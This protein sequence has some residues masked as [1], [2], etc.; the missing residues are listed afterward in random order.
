MRLNSCIEYD[1]FRFCSHDYYPFDARDIKKYVVGDDYTPVWEVLYR[2]SVVISS[3]HSIF[4]T[5]P[6]SQCASQTSLVQFQSFL[7]NFICLFSFNI[8]TKY[9]SLGKNLCA[10]S[11][12]FIIY[13]IFELLVAN[14]LICLC[15]DSFNPTCIF[16]FRFLHLRSCTEN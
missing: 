7:K 15:F 8:G 3:I 16:S 12:F 9:V 13:L 10:C 14:H 4:G 11:L 5:V 6:H 1:C 2:I